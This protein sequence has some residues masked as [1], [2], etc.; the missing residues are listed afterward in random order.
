M[1]V[2]INNGKHS[3]CVYT[4]FDATR[5]SNP[6]KSDIKYYYLLRAWRTRFAHSFRFTDAHELKLESGSDGFNN[7]H[8]ETE[9]LERLRLSDIFLIILTS[10]TATNSKWIPWEISCAID[11]FSLP[12]LC[13]YPNSAM[14]IDQ[15]PNRTLWP[16]ALRERIAEHSYGVIHVPFGLKN[17]AAAIDATTFRAQ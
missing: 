15:F 14:N 6:A 2:E 16:G 11:Q 10:Y 7:S 13:V 4:C 3:P 9:L 5:H 1:S 12:V 17:I 8:L